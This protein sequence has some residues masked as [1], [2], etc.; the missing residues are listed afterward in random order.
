MRKSVIF[1]IVIAAMGWNPGNALAETRD[2]SSGVATGKRAHKPMAIAKESKRSGK[3]K[4]N[5]FTIKKTTD[6]ASP[7]MLRTA[8]PLG[9]A[10]S[11]HGTT[12]SGRSR[13]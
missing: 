10:A 4:F 13:R 8:P 11:G 6:A 9:D 5:E 12:A 1:A 7:A 3:I 2:V